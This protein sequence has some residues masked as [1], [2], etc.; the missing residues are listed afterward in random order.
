ML[1]GIARRGDKGYMGLK[2]PVKGNCGNGLWSDTDAAY[3]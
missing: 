3:M 1:S 2:G